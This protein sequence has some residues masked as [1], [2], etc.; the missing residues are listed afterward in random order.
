MMEFQHAGC[1]EVYGKVFP[2]LFLSNR[3]NF[4]NN[5]WDVSK[6]VGPLADQLSLCD[7]C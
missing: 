4:S 7:S 1:L 5:V 6:F 3:I 2:D